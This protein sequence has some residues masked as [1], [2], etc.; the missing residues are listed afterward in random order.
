V[1]DIYQKVNICSS[2]VP[3]KDQTP[4]QIVKRPKYLPLVSHYTSFVEFFY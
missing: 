3:T 4:N 2:Y 1:V